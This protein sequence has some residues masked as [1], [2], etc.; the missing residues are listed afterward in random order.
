MLFYTVD[1]HLDIIIKRLVEFEKI[2]ENF[3]NRE[4]KKNRLCTKNGMKLSAIN[5]KKQGT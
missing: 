1:T 3:V 4:E 5:V 2:K